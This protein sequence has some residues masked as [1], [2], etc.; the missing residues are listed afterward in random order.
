M[1]LSIHG[2]ESA[3]SGISPATTATNA[4]SGTLSSTST[5]NGSVKEEVRCLFPIMPFKRVS[6]NP[7]AL[8]A[9]GV[10]LDHE[11]VLPVPSDSLALVP[12]H[13]RPWRATRWVSFTAI[14]C[15]LKFM[16]AHHMVE[17]GLGGC[18]IARNVVRD[19]MLL[20]ALRKQGGEQFSC[21]RV[22]TACFFCPSCLQVR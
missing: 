14:I 21:R 10:Q 19:R 16:N 3:S 11:L 17:S 4:S 1:N 5:A 9:S 6:C 7:I 15:W 13:R 18:W 2:D 22:T 12:D 20:G 8:A